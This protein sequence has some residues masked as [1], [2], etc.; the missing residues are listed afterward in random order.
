M[1]S[2]I[3]SISIS[4][5]S[6]LGMGGSFASSEPEVEFAAAQYAGNPAGQGADSHAEEVGYGAGIGDGPDRASPLA[7]KEWIPVIPARIEEN[8]L[9]PEQRRAL[10][11]EIN[12]AG[13]ELYRPR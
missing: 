13:R 12:E 8:R 9:S 6:L 5:L 4:M 10:R 1:N 11:H 7:Y 3:R 2:L